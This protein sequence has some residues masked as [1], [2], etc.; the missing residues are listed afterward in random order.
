MNP[1]H[2]RH[3]PSAGTDWE[4]KRWCRCGFRED[5]KRCHDMSN[6]EETADPLSARI[7]GE[8]DGEDE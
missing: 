1:H 7:L 6:A 3:D 2:F 4:G 8:H 5:N